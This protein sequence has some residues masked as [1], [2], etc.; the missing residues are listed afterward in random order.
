MDHDNPPKP[1]SCHHINKV[2]KAQ[3]VDECLFIIPKNLF[4][5]LNFDE[6]SC[7]D[8]HLYATDFSLSS[9]KLGYNT[10]IIPSY[11]YHLSSGYSLSEEYY[12]TL[13]LL[14]KKH[15]TL[16]FIRTVFGNYNT[17]IPLYIQRKLNPYFYKIFKLIHF[18]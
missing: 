6:I 11:I 5:Q 13:K 16:F 9:K 17:I 7:H 14:L 15:K 1:V 10:Y 3:T 8:W 18:Q 12:N 2:I 4:N